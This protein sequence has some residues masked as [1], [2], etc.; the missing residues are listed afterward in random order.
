MG[1]FSLHI[2]SPSQTQD[3]SSTQAKELAQLQKQVNLAAEQCPFQPK[4]YDDAARPTYKAK[5]AKQKQLDAEADAAKARYEHVHVHFCASTL[6]R[7]SR[8]RAPLAVLT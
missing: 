3:A 6:L 4:L 8:S 7:L 1:S 5:S 2:R